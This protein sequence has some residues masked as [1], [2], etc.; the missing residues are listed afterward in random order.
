MAPVQIGNSAT[1]PAATSNEGDAGKAFEA[2]VMEELDFACGV[3]DRPPAMPEF[4][5]STPPSLPSSP[6]V[7]ADFGA[8]SPGGNDE[9]IADD[10]PSLFDRGAPT[11]SLSPQAAKRRF[12]YTGL[13]MGVCMLAG[14]TVATLTSGKDPSARAFED[15]PVVALGSGPSTAEAPL[16]AAGEDDAK[17][18]AQSTSVRQAAAQGDARTPEKEAQAL[19]AEPSGDELP[20]AESP[21][22]EPPVAKPTQLRARPDDAPVPSPRAVAAPDEIRNYADG[23]AFTSSQL[24]RAARHESQGETEQALSVLSQAWDVFPKD[25]HLAER[26]ARLELSRGQYYPARRWAERAVRLRPTRARYH[27]LMGDVL[28]SAGNERSAREA[29]EQ[30]LEVQPGYP[31]AVSRLR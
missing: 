30:A 20:V 31:D 29:F 27:V 3:S 16:E 8:L 25:P 18:P 9:L 10:R 19:G 7:P 2:L 17:T 15:E 1:P 21:V 5:G 12:A 11:P 13:V 24:R 6:K 28:R 4:A 22:A 14:V 26:A 23:R